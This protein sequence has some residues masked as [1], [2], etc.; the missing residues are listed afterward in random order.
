MLWGIPRHGRSETMSSS[1]RIWL[2]GNGTVVDQ[3]CVRF[4]GS[5]DARCARDSGRARHSHGHQPA[6]TGRSGVNNSFACAAVGR[7]HRLSPEFGPRMLTAPN[8]TNA[9]A[10]FDK[11]QDDPSPTPR[12]FPC[13]SRDQLDVRSKAQKR[14]EAAEFSKK[15]TRNQ[16]ICASSRSSKLAS[17]DAT[18]TTWKVGKLPA[19]APPLRQNSGLSGRLSLLSTFCYT[20][21][22]G[23]RHSN[24]VPNRSGRP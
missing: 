13:F 15:W 10:N 23:R 12:K 14:A 3:P 2:R 18:D 8:A 21:E 5:V 17:V 1:I 19:V 16:G 9:E 4:G 6:P 7:H 24:L 22:H 11:I 20:K